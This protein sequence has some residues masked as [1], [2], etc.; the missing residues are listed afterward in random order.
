MPALKPRAARYAHADPELRGHCVRVQPSGQKTFVIVTRDPDGKQVWATVGPADAVSIDQAR[1]QARDMLTRIREGLPAI[2]AKAETVRDVV[3]NWMRR[4]VEAN[5]LRSRSE[6]VRLVNT[7]ILPALGDREFAW[8]KRSDITKLLDHVED[9]HGKRAAD[10]VL[11]VLGAVANWF[12]TR[13]DGFQPFVTRGMRRQQPHAQARARILDDNE[14]RM[15]W[16]AAEANGTFGGIIRL[17]LLTAQRRTKVAAMKWADLSIDGEWT[18]AKEA[19]E[20][21]T[22]GS[23]VLPDAALA[24]IRQQRR[25]GDNPHVFAGR[26]GGSFHGFGQG[27]ARFDT[28]LPQTLPGW[29]LHDLRRTAR[30]LIEPR[31]RAAGEHSE[32]VLGHSIA[33]VQGVYDRH[34]YRDEKADALK[35]LAA[36]IEQIVTPRPNVLPMARPRR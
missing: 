29:T 16:K 5:Q 18:I 11:A 30:S 15:I 17:A 3:D 28:K 9:H 14:I 19:R 21:G 33:G 24:I 1:D 22:A 13:N 6:I 32:R 7:H 10:Y 23:L 2:A 4:H 25:V 35:R 34:S 20:K 31:R 8:I 26:S 12:A 36:L 27:K